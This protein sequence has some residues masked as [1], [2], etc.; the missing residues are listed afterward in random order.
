MKTNWGHVVDVYCDEGKSA[1]SVSGRPEFKRLL[2][3]VQMGRV[4]LII[5]TEL[6]RL[7]RSI[8]DFCEIWD[9]LKKHDASFITLRESFD[10]TTA[11]GEMMVFNL[12]NFA[13]YERKQTAERIS[14]NWESRAKRGLFNVGT[15]PMGYDRNPKSKGELVVN[16][17]DAQIVR[18]IFSLFL[19]KESLRKTC[20]ALIAQGIFLRRFINK[21]GFEKGG[22]PF[23]VDTLRSLLTNPAYIGMRLAVVDGEK[24]LISAVWKPIISTEIFNQV[25]ARLGLNKNRYKP[26]TWKKYPFP[27]TELITCGECGKHFGGKSGTGRV[28]KHFYYGHAPHFNPTS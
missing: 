20:V 19:E 26:D 12:I 5:A 10:T 17:A 1:K 4:D 23:S 13:Q 2:T 9:L 21:H 27:L 16:E 8:R 7:S 25:E 28:Q 6:S 11:S 14:A 24:K 22:K 18:M 15:I 3:D